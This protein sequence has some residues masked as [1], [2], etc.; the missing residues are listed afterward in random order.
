MAPVLGCPDPDKQYFLE[1]DAL[2]FVL[3]A[4]LFQHNMGGKRREVAYFSK[5]LTPS[6]WNYNIWDREFLAIVAAL[7]HW[8]HL[9]I[10]MQELVV[11]LTNHANL[12]YYHHP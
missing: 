9:L 2:A 5:A 10:G 1:V 11:I 7:W 8:R 12:Q 6:E 4:I 3:A